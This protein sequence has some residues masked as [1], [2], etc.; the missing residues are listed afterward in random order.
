L[1]A[2]GALKPTDLVWKEGLPSW[3]PVHSVEGLLPAGSAGAAPRPFPP[4]RPGPSAYGPQMPEFAT[5]F[6]PVFERIVGHLKRAF[7]TDLQ[8]LNVAE[9]ER[10]QLASQGIEHA[11]VQQYVAWRRSIMLVVILPTFISALSAT[12]SILDSFDNLNTFG[13]LTEVI[14][15]LALYAMPAALIAAILLWTRVRLSRTVMLYGWAVAFLIPVLLALLPLEWTFKSELFAGATDQETELNVVGISLFMSI[16]YFVMFL[17]T[18]LSVIP[19]MLRAC[20]RIKT[21]VP[22][23]TIPGWFLVASAV[24]YALLLLPIFIA[25]TKFAGNVLLLFSIICWIAAPLVYLLFGKVFVHPL[26][27]ASDARQVQVV[28]NISFGLITAAVVFLLLFSMTRKI[29]GTDAFLIGFDE[30]KSVL[31]PW[32]W[33]LIRFVFEYIGRSLYITVV[34]VDMLLL[35]NASVWFRGKEFQAS[36]G[37]ADYDRLVTDMDQVIGTASPLLAFGPFSGVHQAPKLKPP[38]REPPVDLPPA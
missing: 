20:L 23:S 27:Q 34:G 24:M 8:S 1:A 21:L 12:I 25:I 30:K 16:A 29:P 10:T 14:H 2:S 38:S 13:R 11:G 17:P 19:G 3:Q 9:Q 33:D 36:P 28:Y 32:S 37:A 18:V 6:Q 22:A 5:K 31:R 26:T 4:S 35:M 15:I 7:T